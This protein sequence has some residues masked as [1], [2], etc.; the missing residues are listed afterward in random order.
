MTFHASTFI[1]LADT[2]QHSVQTPYT[3]LNQIR[4]F[5]LKLRIEIHLRFKVKYGLYWGNFTKLSVT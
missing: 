2:Q 1:K 3:S 4:Q 5:M